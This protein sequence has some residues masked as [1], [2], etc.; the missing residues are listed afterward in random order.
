MSHN[1]GLITVIIGQAG[2]GKTTYVKNK[3]LKNPV[4]IKD[5]IKVTKCDD[6]YLLGD[7]TI[8]SRTLG[9]DTI[10]YNELN[11]IIKYIGDNPDKNIIAEGD[12][13]N[14]DKFFQFLL[15]LQRPIKLFLFICPLKVSKN[16][17]K[18]VSCIKLP[19][20]K[21]TRTKS[22]RNYLKYKDYFQSEIIK[23]G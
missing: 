14:N 19:F 2:A 22:V 13:I 1:D 9:T 11:K 8:N 10:P 12:R 4:L 16:R 6:N 7:Y 21:A 17:L 5:I 23:N 20:I 15:T 18:E 3:Y